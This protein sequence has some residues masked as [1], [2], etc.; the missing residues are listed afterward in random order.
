MNFFI[1]SSG[2]RNLHDYRDHTLTVN[3]YFP[4]QFIE[5]YKQMIQ[6]ILT[7]HN[8][9]NLNQTQCNYYEPYQH[10]YQYH[11]QEYHW[12]QSAHQTYHTFCDVM[13]VTLIRYN[14]VLPQIF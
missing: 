12:Y 10:H 11:Y 2:I 1:T 9:D 14:A 5:V 3:N 6:S 8:G 13:L 7:S 4:L